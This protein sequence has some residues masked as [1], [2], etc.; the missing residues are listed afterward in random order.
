MMMHFEVDLM[1]LMHTANFVAAANP[2][3][4]SFALAPT[5]VLISINLEWQQ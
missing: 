2:Q 1:A 3:D 5:R 4:F